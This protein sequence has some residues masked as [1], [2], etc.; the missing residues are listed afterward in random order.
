MYENLDSVKINF[1]ANGLW[2]LNVTLAIIMF[3]V[4]LDITTNDFKRLLK[5]PKVFFIGI[6]SQ[7][8][9]L[10]FVTFLFIK[11]VNPMPSIALGLIMVAACPGGNVSNFATKMAGG[12]AA[13]SVSLSAFA[14]AAAVI[15][16]PLNLEIYGNMYAPT[17]QILK[18]VELNPY[19][20][21]KLVLVILGIPLIIGMSVRKKY[22]KTA[23][24]MSVFLKPTSL[25]IFLIFIAVAFY[26][27]LDIFVNYIQ[28]VFLL[29]V[30]HNLIALVQGFY[31]AKFFGL[32]KKNQI[33]I[34]M[35]TGIQNSG[36][37]LLLIFSFFDGLGG[38][39]DLVSS[40]LLA[41]YWSKQEFK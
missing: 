13:L 4:A 14:T 15:M 21:F 27:N 30:A 19:E 6:F 2:A 20:L 28:Y 8:I 22:P 29:V 33:T 11:L 37:G 34:S 41:S 39:W 32:S 38:I 12:N 1:D 16:T 31:V 3:G 40:L 25:I 7:F 5:S 26:N 9:L 10:P 17:A 35:E 24:K 18:S 23:H 36:L